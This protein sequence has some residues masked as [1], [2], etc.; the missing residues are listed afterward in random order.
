MTQTVVGFFDDMSSA[1][2]A[3]DRLHD[4]GYDDDNISV[5]A[6]KESGVDAARSGPSR[7]R[8]SDDDIGPGKGA[9]VG[10]VTGLL[11]GVGAMMIPG[12]GPV[13]AAGPLAAA[14]G[15]GVGVAS[16]AVAGPMISA[17]MDKGVPETDANSYVEG[18]K[19]GGAVVMVETPDADAHEVQETLDACGA[20]DIDEVSGTSREVNRATEPMKRPEGNRS[21]NRPVTERDTSDANMRPGMN[22]RKG[23][24]VHIP[25]VEESLS[26]GKR[27][28]SRGGVR[29]YSHVTETPV[30]QKVNLR[31]EQVRVERRPVN[32][33]ATSADLNA[34]KEGE[35]TMEERAEEAVVGKRARVKEE[36]VV[37]KDVREKTEVVRD[38]VRKT[39]VDVTREPTKEGT[40]RRTPG[41]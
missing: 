36:V 31:E 6:S 37:G 33:D 1:N 39:D 38:K 14:L 27:E 11:A 28:V 34:F 4:I 3:I 13:L 8:T 2:R 21:L 7:V 10:G 16:G 20:V 26:V 23:E 29:L 5:E 35:I 12:I 15:A 25:V 41:R 24:E 22:A 30:E 18:I 40:P 32:R 19:R 9:A 17:F